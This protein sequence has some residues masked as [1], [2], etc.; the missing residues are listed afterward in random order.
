MRILV[1]AGEGILV[2]TT[3][4]HHLWAMDLMRNW[5]QYGWSAAADYHIETFDYPAVSYRDGA[6]VDA[7]LMEGYR[8]EEP[9]T[10]RTKKYDRVLR[11]IPIPTAAEALKSLD[12]PFDVFWHEYSR[13]NSII[14]PTVSSRL[15]DPQTRVTLKHLTLL[16]GAVFGCLRTRRLGDPSIQAPLIRKIYPSGGSRHPTELYVFPVAVHG[17]DPGVYHFSLETNSLDLIGPALSIDQLEQVFPGPFRARKDLDFEP[18]VLMLFTSVFERNM[19]R[20]REP[21][22]FRTLFMEVGHASATLGIVA[23]ALGLASYTHHAIDDELAESLVGINGLIEGSL[24]GAAIG[25]PSHGV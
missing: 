23:T 21:R 3:N 16:C 15:F 19:Y 20:Y 10:A 14:D 24:Y 4:G 11:E 17:M 7:A 13:P 22:T 1:P 9:D 8:S 25:V 2:D 12:V 6:T 5:S 18:S